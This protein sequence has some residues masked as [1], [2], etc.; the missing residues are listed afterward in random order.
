[1]DD[2]ERKRELLQKINNFASA[3]FSVPELNES[4]SLDT[5]EAVYN[6]LKINERRI[7]S[8]DD[9]E[10]EEDFDPDR[11]VCHSCG[12]RNNSHSDAECNNCGFNPTAQRRLDGLVDLLTLA[13]ERRARSNVLSNFID[14]TLDDDNIKIPASDKAIEN[15]ERIEITEEYIKENNLE[16]VDCT[17]CYCKLNESPDD[18][19]TELIK[20]PC[21]HH[22]H[23]GCL[24]QWLEQD[25]TCPVCRKKIE[26]HE[27]KINRM[28][29]GAPT[30]GPAPGPGPV[31]VPRPSGTTNFSRIGPAFSSMTPSVLFRAMNMS[32]PE[33]IRYPDIPRSVYNDLQAGYSE[34]E[35]LQLA[36]A[37]SKSLAE[38]TEA[39]ESTE[40]E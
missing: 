26:Q 18:K 30:F 29:D 3:G 6:T 27:T 8:A 38:A 10:E 32:M 36:M 9:T 33:R 2:T 25:H 28:N 7:V 23:S 37:E 5:L 11:W 31:F 34:D 13:L 19:T 15:L 12:Y 20:M 21:G 16:D 22:F 4:T 39:A 14:N 35:A 40:E 1:M 17:I 24:L